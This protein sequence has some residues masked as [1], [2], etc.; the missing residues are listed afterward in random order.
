MGR[1]RAGARG[2][3]RAD[4]R[5]ARPPRP[6]AAVALLRGRGRGALPASGSRRGRARVPARERAVPQ[7]PPRRAAERQLRRHDGAAVPVRRVAPAAAARARE[8]GRRDHRRD[9][10]QG[11]QG[12]GVSRRAL[13][14]LGD[15][16]R[17]RHRRVAREDAGGDR[18]P[19]D[20]TPA[21]CSRPTRSSSRWSKPGIAA[22]L[23]SLAAP[24]RQ[25][26]DAVFA[27]ATLK[28]PDA[29]FMQ[30]GGKRGVH[31]EHLG[32][33]LAEMQV[34]QRSYPGARW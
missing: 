3:H 23:R 24:W 20:C 31:T 10:R 32:H 13:G 26:V 28:A 30:Q 16:P 33:L 6:G 9:R 25:Q 21:R 12:G 18:R 22:D 27:A 1:P 29:A 19:L 2:G 5:G 34:L 14:R 11:R 7:S 17:R 4:Q 8:V 15:P